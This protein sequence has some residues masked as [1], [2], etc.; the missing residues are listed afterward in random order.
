MTREKGF[1][2]AARVISMV[3]TP[4]YLPTLGLMV[5]FMFSYMS[6][7]PWS[8]KFQLLAMV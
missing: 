7:M 6:Q 3:F 5:L 4:F 2:L 8:Y 1:I